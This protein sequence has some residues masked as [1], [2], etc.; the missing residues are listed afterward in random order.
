MSDY[1]IASLLKE[2]RIAGGFSIQDIANYLN[3]SKVAVSK[4]ENGY[5]IKVEN[6]YDLSK[7]YNI[8]V[9]ELYAG[10]LKEEIDEIYL[11]R[12]Y[13]LSEF[14]FGNIN[15]KSIDQIKEF[16]RRCKALKE[17]FYKLLHKWANDELEDKAIYEFNYIKKYFKFDREYYKYI[18]NINVYSLSM[19]NIDFEKEFI[20]K[21]LNDISK[22]CKDCYN[23]EI[24]KIYDFNIDKQ[25]EIIINTQNEMALD[26]MLDV[27]P[28]IEKDYLLYI[29]IYKEDINKKVKEIDETDIENNIFI[30]KLIDSDAKMLYVYR[31][32]DN[33]WDEE[34]FNK[35][36]GKSKELVQT[37]Y[38]TYSFCN[39]IRQFEIPIFNNWKAYTFE[40]YKD[41]VD[42]EETNRIK[43]IIY[44]KNQKPLDYYKNLLKRDGIINK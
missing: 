15:E 32:F 9:D 31:N 24:S 18:S 22:L 4:W 3:V 29:N 20:K 16:Y 38:K 34:L 35:I 17:N 41:F 43:D 28:Q 23:W 7:L 5:D 12:N 37:I 14:N 36:E 21:R 1:K 6:L 33:L 39:Y 19:S 27:I 13:D 8:T 42:E 26:N 10:K 2:L 40:N 44:L 30:K 25:N 11:K